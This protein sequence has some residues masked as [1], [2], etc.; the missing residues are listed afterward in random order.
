[1]EC[2]VR[3]VGV[4]KWKADLFL[5]YLLRETFLVLIFLLLFILFYVILRNQADSEC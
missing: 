3:T 1:M 5:I 4:N 2:A